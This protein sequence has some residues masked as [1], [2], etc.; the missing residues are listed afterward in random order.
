MAW[1]HRVKAPEHKNIRGLFPVFSSLC[2]KGSF[3]KDGKKCLNF[4]PPQHEFS[5]SIACQNL[6][7]TP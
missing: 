2:F 1:Y 7:L 5:D 6:K 3:V 4:S